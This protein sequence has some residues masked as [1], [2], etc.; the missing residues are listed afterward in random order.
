VPVL[1]RLVHESLLRVER[2]GEVE[3]LGVVCV[4]VVSSAPIVPFYVVNIADERVP[5]TGIIGMSNVVAPRNT[6]GRYL[7]YLPKYLLSGDP[8][9]ERDAGTVQRDF[10]AGLRRMLP[11]F[12][13]ATI[14]SV[15]VNRAQRV[16]PLQVLDYS[17]LVPQ[18]ATAHPDFFVLNTAQFVD[19]T[20]NNNEVVGA[21]NRFCDGHPELLAA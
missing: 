6:A 10:I 4:V 12:D 5:F 15:H 14:E 8:D 9:L 7:T 2:E 16:Q 19:A 11:G 1:R 21:V 13:P 17:K 3:Y 20:L 18:V